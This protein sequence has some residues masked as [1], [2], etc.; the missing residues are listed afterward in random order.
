MVDNF[1]DNP[2]QLS[3]IMTY[4]GHCSNSRILGPVRKKI[5]RFSP[6]CSLG[7]VQ[8]LGCAQLSVTPW[9]AAHQASLS[10]TISQSL[11]K[12]MSV[13]SMMSSY[14]LILWLSG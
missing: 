5:Q 3:Q 12:F 2:Q 11:L 4:L 7:V 14:H 1:Q 13:E 6:L 9:T 8:S 10:F